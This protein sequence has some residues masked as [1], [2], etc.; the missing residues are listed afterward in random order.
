M[1]F[2]SPPNT[3]WTH[4]KGLRE[5]AKTNRLPPRQVSS[6]LSDFFKF[7]QNP[8]RTS[9]AWR[10]SH[11]L[12]SVSHIGLLWHLWLSR[13]LCACAWTPV[14]MLH[15]NNPCAELKGSQ[16]NE[17]QRH[18]PKS[19]GHYVT[20]T[21]GAVRNVKPVSKVKQ[22]FVNIIDYKK[23]ISNIWKLI[24]VPLKY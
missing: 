11:S 22:M 8:P 20:V 5:Q 17:T 12:A 15:L 16:P 9:G 19:L 7:S 23:Y 13:P 4:H 10:H 3:R 2:S 18:K 21:A 14:L 6:Q 1:A 24:W